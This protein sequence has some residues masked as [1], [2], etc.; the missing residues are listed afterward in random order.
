L[1]YEWLDVES[2]TTRERYAQHSR[3]TFDAVLELSERVSADHFASHNRAS[4]SREP[5]LDGGDIKLIPE[6]KAALDIF[7]RTGLIGASMD[8]EV[9]GMQLPHAV[10]AACFAWFQAAN[11]STSAYPFLTV[12][13]ANLLM[14][15]GTP[16][17]I[18][19]YVRPMVDGRFFGTMTPGGAP[20]ILARTRWMMFSLRLWSPAE[21]HILC[22]ARRKVWSPWGSA[23]V[24]MSAR[25]D[26]ACGSDRHIKE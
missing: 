25:D 9:G 26:P 17:Q 2:L 5:A 20:V 16:E 6:V 13:N 15:Y 4:D 18:D 11:I 19:T 3:A 1:L 24:S 8:E 22:P 21:I 12:A 7:G 14:E 10:A 23:R